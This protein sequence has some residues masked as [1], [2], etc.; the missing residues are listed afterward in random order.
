[1]TYLLIRI[2]FQVKFLGISVLHNIIPVCIVL[3]H[4]IYTG[5]TIPLK[6]I[7]S[8]KGGCNLAQSLPNQDHLANQNQPYSIMTPLTSHGHVVSGPKGQDYIMLFNYPKQRLGPW[9]PA[10][11]LD[12]VACLDKQRCP[13]GQWFQ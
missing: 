8:Y 4:K 7:Q 2:I 10:R 1:M 13:V 3:D 9:Q 12:H 11:S 6:L 5:Y